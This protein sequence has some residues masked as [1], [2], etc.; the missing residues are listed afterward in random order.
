VEVCRDGHN[1]CL[2]EQELAYRQHRRMESLLRIVN[3]EALYNLGL[4]CS[5][6]GELERAGELLQRCVAN[7]P[8]NANGW[9]ALEPGNPYALRSYGTLLLLQGEPKEAVAVLQRARVS[10]PADPTTLLTLAQALIEADLAAHAGE[11]DQLLRQVLQLVPREIADKAR[12]ASMR[13]AD[14]NLHCS[15]GEG[16][17]KVVVVALGEALRA[18]AALT[19]EQG[20]VVLMEAAIGEKGLAMNQPELSYRLETLPGAFSGLQ[21]VALIEISARQVLGLADGG[22]G[23]GAEVEQALRQQG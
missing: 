9:V 2:H 6:A 23:F 16:L 1:T 14:H 5:D 22:F 8:A 7:G 11:A 10:G 20:K 17:R 12:R 13:I 21:L 3:D 18:Y 4:L 19:V 15:Q